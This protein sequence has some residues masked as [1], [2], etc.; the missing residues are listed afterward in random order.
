MPIDGRLSC[1]LP[2]TRVICWESNYDPALSGEECD[3]SSWWVDIGQVLRISLFVENSGAG[4]Q[5][6]ELGKR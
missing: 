1:D 5:D 3:I 4:T 6:E 2:S